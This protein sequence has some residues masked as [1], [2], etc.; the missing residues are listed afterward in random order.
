MI[1]ALWPGYYSP[2][3]LPMTEQ[4]GTAG[5]DR[6]AQAFTSDRGGGTIT[7]ALVREESSEAAAD[8]AMQMVVAKGGVTVVP[9][10]SL[11][12]RALMVRG[13]D[14]DDLTLVM[15]QGEVVICINLVL[16][17][18]T[19]QNADWFV[20]HVGKGQLELLIEAGY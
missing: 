2:A 12:D 13:I 18:T 8:T 4:L 11:T 17:G 9:P 19:D 7:V 6:A 16:G 15:T 1:E 10:M 20:A 14:P 5:V 3:P